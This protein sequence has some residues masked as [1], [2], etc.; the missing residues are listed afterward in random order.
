MRRII[1]TAL[2][3]SLVVVWCLESSAGQEAAKTAAETQAEAA[4]LAII[5]LVTLQPGQTRELML[6]TWCTVGLTRSSGFALT[7]MRDGK[8]VVS[9]EAGK[10]YNRDGVTMTVPHPDKATA[11]ADSAIFAPLKKRHLEA[12]V[13]TISASAD[14]KPGLIEM[15]LVDSTCSGHCHSHFRVLVVE[16]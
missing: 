16:K 3:L 2:L 12:F 14:A 9:T 15:H 5:P 13:V 10:S 11:F 4:K 1:V 8:P 7:E 6:S